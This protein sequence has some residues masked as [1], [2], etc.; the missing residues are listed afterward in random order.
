MLQVTARNVP[1]AFSEMMIHTKMRAV[2]EDSRNGPVWTHQEPVLLEILR[3]WERVLYDPIRQANPYFHLMEF[4][5]MMSGTNRVEFPEFYNSRFREYAE[6][7]GHLHAAYGHRWRNFFGLDQIENAVRMLKTNPENRR[8]V[9]G[10]WHPGEDMGAYKNDLPCN[11]HIYFRVVRGH[12]EMTV[13]NR[14]ND[15]IWGM[16]GANAVHMTLLH[17]LISEA[18]GIPMGT[19]RVFS[20]NAHMY[21]ALP[22]F[23]DLLDVRYPV[24][25]YKSGEAIPSTLLGDGQSLQEFLHCCQVFVEGDGIITGDWFSTVAVPMDCAYK[26]RKNGDIAN[27]RVHIAAVEDSAWRLACQSWEDWKNG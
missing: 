7:D 23:Q 16:L 10:M 17:Q 11:T 15:I 5:W 14:S 26:A 3:P 24:D 25:P 19:Y 27:S 9:L 4:I 20:I 6:E 18:T 22:N 8:V 21:E 12:L 13:C 2:R 1:E